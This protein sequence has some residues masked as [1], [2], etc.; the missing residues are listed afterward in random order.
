MLKTL[1]KDDKSNIIYVEPYLPKIYSDEVYDLLRN[2]V[3]VMN[4]IGCVYDYIRSTV[5]QIFFNLKTNLVIMY[6]M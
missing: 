1:L 6:C 5:A 4:H 2:E 3:C